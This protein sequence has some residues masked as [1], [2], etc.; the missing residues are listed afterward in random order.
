MD[1]NLNI[2]FPPSSCPQR[3]PSL[4][5]SQSISLNLWSL[6]NILYS[7]LRWERRLE[8]L[9][10]EECFFLSWDEALAKSFSLESGSLLWRRLWMNFTM[11]TFPS[12]MPEPWVW[13]FLGSSSGL[14]LPSSL[15]VR[16]SIRSLYLRKWRH[17][18]LPTW[19][20]HGWVRSRA[21]F[22][23]HQDEG[24]EFC[25]PCFSMCWFLL[26]PA[27]PFSIASAI[28]FSTA[29]GTCEPTP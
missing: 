2:A 8:G 6:L 19:H 7:I 10:L 18:Y 21:S 26:V 24:F 4:Q 17:I 14:C 13:I 15:H 3:Q 25:Q 9:E 28:V 1:L 20:I 12:P 11:I 23:N 5:H 16:L 29:A 27:S 22:R